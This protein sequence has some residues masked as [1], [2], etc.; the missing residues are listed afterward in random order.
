[1]QSA[2]IPSEGSGFKQTTRSGGGNAGFPHRPNQ[3]STNLPPA[4]T[5]SSTARGYI[6]DV[7]AWTSRKRST[8]SF[9][10]EGWRCGE[11][12]CGWW[13]TT[14]ARMRCQLKT[15]RCWCW[16]P[17]TNARVRPVPPHAPR[18]PAACAFEASM[19]LNVRGALAVSSSIVDVKAVEEVI[20]A[21]LEGRDDEDEPIEIISSFDMPKYSYDP[22]K[23]AFWWYAQLTLPSQLFV[24]PRP[25][26]RKQ[27]A[28]HHARARTKCYAM[29]P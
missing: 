10:G 1:M 12:Q 17:W 26:S 5:E 2:K 6:T 24:A 21:L 18:N 29:L 28:V 22:I 4:T 23:R 25:T 27:T 3:K 11:S 13:Q 15:S 9:G 8:P 20:E 19:R 14:C 16:T 7:R